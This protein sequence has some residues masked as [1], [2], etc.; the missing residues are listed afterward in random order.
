MMLHRGPAD[1]GIL[2]DERVLLGHRRFSIIDLA[3]G[4]QP[5]PTPDGVV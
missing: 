5:M 3:G 1:F 4:H 2:G